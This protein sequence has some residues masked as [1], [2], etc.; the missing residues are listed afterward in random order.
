MS[1][2][3][4]D[5][6]IELTINNMI[7]TDSSEVMF[8]S[9]DPVVIAPNYK[10]ILSNTVLN[11]GDKFQI[12]G[13]EGLSENLEHNF[14]S[15]VCETLDSASIN[16]NPKWLKLHV[17]G[18]DSNGK[19]EMLD[20]SLLW[21]QLSDSKHHYYYMR[22]RKFNSGEGSSDYDEYAD[23]TK[24]NYAVYTGNKK[25]TLGI[26]AELECINSFNTTWDATVGE[27]TTTNDTTKNKK[28][29]ITNI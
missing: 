23:L 24:S 25:I 29:T 12:Y 27:E 5:N 10:I 17:I 21:E 26:L 4:G 3:L 16:K 1:D 13:H 11:P 22:P 28:V 19:I 18:Q 14:I 6:N 20:D 2:K 9:K 15:G 7:T 8:T